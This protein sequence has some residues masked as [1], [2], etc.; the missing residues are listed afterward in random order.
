MLLFAL[1]FDLFLHM[2]IAGFIGGF[3]LFRYGDLSPAK[4]ETTGLVAFDWNNTLTLKCGTW[5][6]IYSL[7][8]VWYY[9]VSCMDTPM[10]MRKY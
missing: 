3:C 6:V 10:T 9:Y 8:S 7:L 4:D 5:D 2:M 1:K